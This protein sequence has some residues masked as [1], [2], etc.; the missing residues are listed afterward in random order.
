MNLSKYIYNL[1]KVEDKNWRSWI[2]ATGKELPKTFCMSLKKLK[3]EESKDYKTICSELFVTHKMLTDWMSG[4]RAIP[5][6]VLKTLEEKTNIKLINKIENLSV[7]GSQDIKVPILSKKL[8]EIIGRH[9]GDGS[10]GI[11]KNT[12]RVNIKE[13]KSLLERH[14]KDLRE[15]LG[16]NSDIKS[17]GV[18][19]YID[20]YSKIFSRI[21]TEIFCIP[22]GEEKTYKAKEPLI[23][24]SL[25][26]KT[27]KY[28][29]RGLI[30]TD[31]WI[32]YYK[33]NKTFIL[34]FKV[35]NEHLA[36]S[37]YDILTL[38]NFRAHKRIKGKYFQVDFV[39]KSNIKRYLEVV[40]SKNYR[41]L[42]KVTV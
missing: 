25:P 15:T 10:C 41:L 1:H 7:Y 3:E 28:F 23:I 33:K 30:D 31:G 16:I 9:C 29:L 2:R 42:N 27:R 14:K 6:W 38:L 8:V 37:V 24:K 4:R 36:N 11:Y 18:V 26:L 32:Y 34:G 35:V 22:L 17:D 40:G 21:I 5:L 12:Y 39:G 13:H 20:N 19:Y